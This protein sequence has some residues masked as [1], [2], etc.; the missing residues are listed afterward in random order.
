MESANIIAAKEIKLA[1]V[2][3]LNRIE[4]IDVLRGIALLGILLMNI[5]GFSMPSRYS[6]IFRTDPENVN[7]WVRAVILV[8]FEGKMRA[9][10]SMLFGAGILLFT[11]KKEAAGKSTTFLFYRRMGWLVLFGLADAHILLWEGDILYSY[12]VIGMI[13]FL[14]RKMKPMYLAFGVPLVAILDFGLSHSFYKDMR[15][16]RLDYVKVQK[17]IQAG[18]K[19][20]A[21]QQTVLSNWR[22]IEKEFIPNEQDIRDNTKK[23]KSD[24][25]TVAKKIRKSSWDFQTKYLMYT[26]ADP[27]ALMLLGM[28][29]LKWGFFTNQWSKRQYK[30]TILLG[31]GLGLPLVLYDFYY[32]FV[33]MPNLAASFVHMEQHPIVWVNIIYPF[34]RIL[35]V[36]AHASLVMLIIR[37]G[38]MQSLLNK[39]AAVGQMAFTNYVMHT[40]ICTL[41]FFGYGLNYYATLEYYQIFYVVFAIW[42]LQIFLSPLW[43]RH[44]Y[45]GPLEWLWRSLTYWKIQPMRR[46]NQ[47]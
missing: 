26:I 41:F 22:E 6:E 2:S 28:A 10:F 45:F 8:V 25:S 34:Q 14:F 35:L 11:T 15:Q 24:Y 30:F 46:R 44:F 5:P 42:I 17:E 29:F 31:Y 18:D 12:G 33:N 4:T 37:S 20:S 13:A 43:L 27:L 3:Q 38:A 32:G 1:P 40:V 16:K 19:P 7:F 9:L 21:A 39:L 23:M 36:M 47:S